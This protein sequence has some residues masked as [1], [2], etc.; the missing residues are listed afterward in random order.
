MKVIPELISTF[1]LYADEISNNTGTE[2]N[3][4]DGYKR[5]RH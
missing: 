4:Q 5:T 1:F 2:E 3:K